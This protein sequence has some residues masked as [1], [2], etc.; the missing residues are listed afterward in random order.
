MKPIQN[1]RAA[2]SACRS[3]LLLLLCCCF[4]FRAEAQRWHYDF[5]VPDNGNFAAAVQ[6]A[7]NRPDKSRRFRIFVRASN[8]RLGQTKVTLRASNTSIIGEARQGTQIETC[9]QEAGLDSG[10]T[11]LIDG[12]QDTY[13]QDLELWSNLRNDI[14]LFNG[15][16]PTLRLRQARRTAMKNVCLRGTENTLYSDAATAAARSNSLYAEDCIL[17]GTVDY[18]AG[19]GTA[20]FDHCDLTLAKRGDAT[21]QAVICAPATEAGLP[22]GFVF[23]D[24]YIDGPRHQHGRYL[25]GRPLGGKA[26]TAWLNCCFN[27]T[28]DPE[29]W[30]DFYHYV[31]E[32]MAEY[33][34]TDGKFRMLDLSK[35]RT[36]FTNPSGRLTQTSYQPRLNAEVAERYTPE[37]V[38]AE[39][40]PRTLTELLPPPVLRIKARQITWD[41]VPEA[42]C[43][44]VERDR[45]VVAFVTEPR[46][47]VPVGVREGTCYTVRCANQMG[48]LGVSSAQVVFSMR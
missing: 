48:G 14:T 38:F 34:S 45:K 5:I 3:V 1:K 32:L 4:A 11:L 15:S 19:G 43:Y 24:C 7:N 44:A 29:A 18:L 17:V 26:R 46:Y 25:L 36:Q 33:E 41:D 47:T 28:P 21:R 13:L 23:A 30:G 6:A 37:N 39:W 8:Y 40:N 10:W 20:F 27:I 16:A 2:T 31:P 42:G 22:Y 35:R 9:P 12:A